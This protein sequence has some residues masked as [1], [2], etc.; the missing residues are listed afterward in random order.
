MKYVWVSSSVSQENNFK[1]LQSN[2]PFCVPQLFDINL[3]LWPWVL[4]AISSQ[5]VLISQTI[6]SLLNP[7]PHFWKACKNLHNIFVCY[8]PIRVWK[9]LHCWL[10]SL[11]V[12][13]SVGR[14]IP[15]A[16]VPEWKRQHELPVASPW[17]WVQH[18]HQPHALPAPCF[19]HNNGVPSQIEWKQI[20]PCLSCFCCSNNQ[21]NKCTCWSI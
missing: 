1:I 10:S 14:A 20:P 15:W 21:S 6:L 11:A 7:F 13:L 2:V 16:G 5:D 18:D 4:E 3:V 12:F 17:L 8:Y 19:L 9:A